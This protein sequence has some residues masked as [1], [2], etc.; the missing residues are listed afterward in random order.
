MADLIEDIAR[1]YASRLEAH[2]ATPR[3][4]DWNGEEGQ[5]IRFEQICKVIDGSSP[6]TLNDIGCGYGALVDYLAIRYSGFSYLGVDIA[7]NMVE[8][9][10]QLHA[11]EPRAAF[12]H[13]AVPDRPADYS[14]ASGIFNV[15]LNHDEAG[16]IRYVE[17]TLERINATSLRGFAFNCLTRYSDPERMRA[18]LFYADPGWLFDLCK[19]RFSRNVALLHDYDLY[20]FTL[21]VRK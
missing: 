4:V 15:R 13:G 19:T 12:Q 5:M 17:S 6:F 1:Y 18:D 11:G 2:G 20:E 8:S 21:V 3:G 10:R 16:W 9:A 14:V 7:E